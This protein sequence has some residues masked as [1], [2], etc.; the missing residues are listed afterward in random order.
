[1]RGDLVFLSIYMEKKQELKS[2]IKVILQRYPKKRAATMSLLYLFQSV[3]GYVS[4]SSIEEIAEIVDTAK[5][6]VNSVASFYTMYKRES[7]GDFLVG[8]C[9]NT[10]CAVLGGEH[11]YKRL[12]GYIKEKGIGNRVALERLECNAA[13]DKGPVIMINWEFVDNCR[14]EKVVKILERLLTGEKVISDRGSQIM[15]FKKSCRIIALGSDL[16]R[17]E[18]K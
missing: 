2:E 9:I 1:M 12:E 18:S 14:F 10:M 5:A 11:L 13:C 15:N 16:W 7:I 8:V 4:E 6:E 17:L 3:D